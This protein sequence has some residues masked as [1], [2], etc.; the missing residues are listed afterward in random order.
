VLRG[1]RSMVAVTSRSS[2]LWAR[3]HDR[4]LGSYHAYL[5]YQLGHEVTSWSVSIPGEVGRLSCD[6]YDVTAGLLV[7][8]RQPQPGRTSAWRSGNWLIICALRPSHPAGDTTA[9]ST[10]QRSDQPDLRPWDRACLREDRRNGVPASPTKAI[11]TDD[12]AKWPPT[13]IAH[14]HLPYAGADIFL[15]LYKRDVSSASE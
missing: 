15:A 2:S 8:V 10:Q 9:G 6:L 13:T 3:P 5:T 4:L 12:H 14:W 7:E 11:R 1:H